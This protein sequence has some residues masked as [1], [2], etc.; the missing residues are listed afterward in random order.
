[1]LF[2]LT[3]HSPLL[4]RREEGERIIIEVFFRGIVSKKKGYKNISR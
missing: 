1:L 2:F 4:I 3:P